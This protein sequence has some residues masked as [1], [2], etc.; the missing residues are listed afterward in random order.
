MRKPVIYKEKIIR[1]AYIVYNQK[2]NLAILLA[3]MKPLDDFN[4]KMSKSVYLPVKDKTEGAENPIK[5]AEKLRETSIKF[6]INSIFLD[7]EKF[8]SKLD[9]TYMAAPFLPNSFQIQ[10]KKAF[11]S[12]EDTLKN[13]PFAEKQEYLRLFTERIDGRYLQE[14]IHK[15]KEPYINLVFQKHYKIPEQIDPKDVKF[16]DSYQ[17]FY[18]LSNSV[19]NWLIQ[20]ELLNDIFERASLY[21]LYNV[22]A[23]EKKDLL[24]QLETDWS[25]T[26]KLELTGI[27]KKLFKKVILMSITR[28]SELMLSKGFN[29]ST[30]SWSACVAIISYIVGQAAFPWAIIFSQISIPWI[31]GGFLA[32]KVLTQIG[33]VINKDELMKD[34]EYLKN[35]MDENSTILMEHYKQISKSMEKCFYTDSEEEFKVFK[36]ALRSHIEVFL[37]ES[38]TKRVLQSGVKTDLKPLTESKL[39]LE[40]LVVK[41]S[42][43][44]DW[45]V[46]EMQEFDETNEEDFIVCDFKQ[47]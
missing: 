11:Y 14:F 7:F 17:D 26:Q 37:D 24:K 38:E 15:I 21:G 36:A 1:I 10:R 42:D 23:E 4:E 8:L 29:Y 43:E 27:A 41:E 44:S 46:C 35:I 25:A 3:N 20:I 13:L 5:T 30:I 18:T 6:K 12:L 33:K 16:S 40:M 22:K 32:S 45:V 47:T 28:L 31:A 2:L 9:F 19:A 39:S 34:I